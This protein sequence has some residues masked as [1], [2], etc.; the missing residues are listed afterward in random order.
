MVDIYFKKSFNFYEKYL[1]V[2]LLITQA[3]KKKVV[4]AGVLTIPDPCILSR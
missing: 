4:C 2:S 3:H 1:G